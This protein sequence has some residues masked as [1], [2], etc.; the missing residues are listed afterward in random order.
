MSRKDILA[1]I[2]RLS[3]DI[4]RLLYGKGPD[5]QGAVL[6]DL[7]SMWVAGHAPVVRDE[8]M[9]MHFKAIRELVPESEKQM[10]G[11]AG[12]PDRRWQEARK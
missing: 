8:L 12:H 1:E 4:G 9:E 7:C 6:A 2:E 11:E 10:F 3:H 5:M